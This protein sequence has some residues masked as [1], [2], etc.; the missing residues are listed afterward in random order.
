M[1]SLLRFSEASWLALHAMT[2]LAVHR[3]QA[4]SAPQLARACASSAQHMS[5]VCRRLAGAGLLEAVRGKQ[6]GFR[7]AIAP[8]QIRLSRVLAALGE[9]L[10]A[11]GCVL[12]HAACG[13]KHDDACIFGPELAQLQAR[14][15]GFFHRATLAQLARR[16]AA[17]GQP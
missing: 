4:V 9:A 5:K 8:G 1:P 17:G 15:A 10:D 11:Q 13:H 7:L 14:V 16:C 2:F 6:G 3:G 12:A